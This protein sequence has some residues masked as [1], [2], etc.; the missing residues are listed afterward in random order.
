MKSVNADFKL[1]FD[2]RDIRS[3]NDIPNRN[4][5]DQPY[6]VVTKDGNWSLCGRWHH[7]PVWRHP[8]AVIATVRPI[9]ANGPSESP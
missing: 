3:D 1:K 5:V 7:G 2:P 6:F 4:Y 8:W 9:V